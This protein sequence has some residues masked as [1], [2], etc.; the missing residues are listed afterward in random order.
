[1]I[2]IL[3]ARTRDVC[4]LL[5]DGHPLAAQT[6]YD[7]RPGRPFESNANQGV[8]YYKLIL[9]RSPWTLEGSAGVSAPA[10]SFRSLLSS[11]TA[12]CSL[13]SALYGLLSLPIALS[14]SHSL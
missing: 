7:G 13:L 14:L 4:P 8:N 11:F 1:M 10:F 5:S 3:Q 2:S 12:V 6:T 9:R